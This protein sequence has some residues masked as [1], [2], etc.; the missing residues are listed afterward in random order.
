LSSRVGPYEV[1]AELV[2]APGATLVEVRDPDGER[3]LLQLLRLRTSENDAQRAERHKQERV[4]AQR[5]A[6]LAAEGEIVVHAHGA[7]DVSTWDGADSLNGERALFWVL[8]WSD[9]PLLLERAKARP[10]SSLDVVRIGLQ[11]AERLLMRHTWG[12]VDPLLSEHV[13]RISDAGKVQIAGVPLTIASEWLGAGMAPPRIAPEEAKTEERRPSGDLWRLGKTLLALAEKSEPVPEATRRVLDDLANDEVLARILSAARAIELLERCANAPR[14]PSGVREVN[15]P[16][17]DGEATQ[18]ILRPSSKPNLALSSA[19]TLPDTPSPFAD[20]LSALPLATPSDLAFPDPAMIASWESARDGGDLFGP[21]AVTKQSEP[22]TPVPKPGGVV[23]VDRTDPV[24]AVSAPTAPTPLSRTP[25][26]A[27]DTLVEM[28]RILS[29]IS[30]PS[31]RI[32]IPAPSPETERV[33]PRTPIPSSSVPTILAEATLP[34]GASP[35]SLEEADT[36]RPKPAEPTPENGHSIPLGAMAAAWQQP[37]L[38][39]GESPWSEVVHARGTHTRAREDFPGYSGEIP[40][41]PFPERRAVPVSELDAFTQPAPAYEPETSEIEVEIAAALKG[42][43]AKKATMFAIGFLA[44]F[45]VFALLSRSGKAPE[46]P[47]AALVSSTNEVLLDSDPPG[48]T[49]VAEGDGAILGKA[50]LAF[51]VPHDA[52]AAVFLVAAGREPLRLLLPE[53]GGITAKL[54]PLDAS[55]C[56]IKLTTA[57]RIEIEGIGFDLGMPGAERSIPGAGVVRAKSGGRSRGARLV[58]CPALGGP[59]EQELR[60][61]RADQAH[62]VKI[63]QPEGSAA[64][65]NGDPIGSV[66][67]GGETSNAFSRVQIGDQ[68][69]NAEERFVPTLENVEVRM[70]VPRPRP[71]PLLVAPDSTEFEIKLDETAHAESSEAKDAKPAADGEGAQP[72]PQRSKLTKA[73]RIIRAKALLKAGTKLLLAGRTQKAKDALTE[74]V[75]LDP[76]AAECHRNLGTL[77][78]RVRAT[79][80]AREHFGRYLELAPDAP[81]ADRI[82]KMLEQ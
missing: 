14:Q 50:P 25:A 69:G 47:A 40:I 59:K 31:L 17:V 45:G 3:R 37:V 41:P 53:R 39:A 21:E 52:H 12:K 5:T 70:P 77:Y 58:T 15:L 66:P 26:G 36:E 61:E 75:E 65:L 33:E 51:L 24:P 44:M 29:E 46:K 56:T 79:H 35:A 30:Q 6:E 38:P 81:D 71:T 68:N 2:Q 11:I 23:I 49:V 32:I 72:D 80:K 27:H 28:P 7:T 73:Q 48:A 18:S 54:A 19:T 13:L 60:F 16:K 8:P 9:D 43:N 64:Y 42:F 76:Q 22:E 74:C 67:T 4:L 78:R 20:L 63:V 82:R 34:D 55:D 62:T 10:L 57:E 1:V